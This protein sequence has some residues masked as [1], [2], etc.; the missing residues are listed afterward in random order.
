MISILHFCYL[1]VCTHFSTAHVIWLLAYNF[2]N[3][4]E[5]LLMTCCSRSLWCPRCMSWLTSETI[6]TYLMITAFYPK[7]TSCV[8]LYS[9]LQDTTGALRSV[10]KFAPP[11]QEKPL[12]N[13]E[14]KPMDKSTS[15]LP[16]GLQG[17]IL[18]PSQW[19]SWKGSSC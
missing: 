11:H 9:A 17:G 14:Q 8:F 10:E 7:T 18:C 5:A 4:E 6:L 19:S 3:S 2:K 13:E 12:L 16:G 15:W 1:C